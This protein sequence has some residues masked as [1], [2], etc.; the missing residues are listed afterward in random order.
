M[1][2]NKNRTGLS[3]RDFLKLSSAA[4]LTAV[5][6]YAL[7]E[8][9]PWLSYNDQSNLTWRPMVKETNTPPQMRELVRYA[10]LA[11]NGHNTQP[12]KF[13]IKENAIEIHPD[14]SRQ[15]PAVDPQNREL[16][17]SLGCALENL[18]VAARA[19]GFT[20]EVTY[21]D[22]AD[23]I[24]VQLTA[25]TPLESPLFKA[26]P[27][28]QNTRSE[29]DGQPVVVTDLDQI[30]SPTLEPGIGVRLIT[31]P[32]ALEA[33]VEYVNQG[34]LSQYTDPSF[35]DELIYW[36]RFNK[37]DALATL[38]GLYSRCS[39]NPEVPGWL[40]RMFVAGTKPQQQAD[41]D[42]AKLR[43]SP[44]AIVIASEADDKS[45]WVRTGQV[46]ERLALKMT[47]L[48]IKSA[49]LNQ[50]IETAELR[51]QFQNAV[52][53]DTSLPQLLVRFGYAE[54]MPRSLRRPV[55][56]VLL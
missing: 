49:F 41:I 45:A 14:F 26:I 47:S 48:N 50:P 15:L 40:G 1:N 3:R 38:D 37:K 30:Q 18:I 22:M 16:W 4:T 20:P 8:Y 44:G 36:L 19:T 54:A 46:Y 9:Q 33:V 31:N 2:E 42:A 56:A 39:G 10:T 21:P 17:I 34:N 28:R 55:E 52:G 23:F 6:G 32:A 43:S 35:I 51:S 29:F 24:N 53:L 12:W 5:A 7:Y 13:A 11:A 27:L 25:D